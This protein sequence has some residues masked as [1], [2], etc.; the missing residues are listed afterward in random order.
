MR[1]IHLRFSGLQSYREP[2]EIDFQR[3]TEVGLFG[4]FGPTGSGKSTILDAITLSLYGKVERAT[5]N[6]Q[7]IMN[8]NA[9]Q[10]SVSFAFALGERLFRV[11]RSYRR[12][13]S[14]S[15]NIA[16]AR[17]IEEKDG[18]LKVLADKDSTVKKAVEELLGLGVDDF[19][20][21]V[22]LPQGKFAEFL[23]LSGKERRDMLER[24][25]GLSA[26][27][28]QLTER[29]RGRLAEYSGQLAQV[30]AQQEGLGDASQKALQEA[31]K[32]HQAASLTAQTAEQ[33]L[34]EANTAFEEGQKILQLQ[35]ELASVLQKQQEHQASAPAVAAK[36]LELTHSEKAEPLRHLLA[37][38][39]AIAQELAQAQI[40]AQE[41][42]KRVM[43][44]KVQAQEA[45]E[46]ALGAEEQLKTQ[47][48]TL[49]L[50][51]RELAEAVEVEGQLA[52][53]GAEG[54]D[55]AQEL[56]RLEAAIASSQANL[57]A[58]RKKRTVSE[59]ELAEFQKARLE[60]TISAQERERLGKASISLQ[61]LK[62]QEQTLAEV[63]SKYQEVLSLFRQDQKALQE[64][65]TKLLD[66]QKS[67]QELEAQ[68]AAHVQTAPPSQQELM[69]LSEKLAAKKTAVQS[70]SRLDKEQVAL[71]LQLGKVK[72][73]Q[74]QKTILKTELAGKVAAQE[75]A[76]AVLKEA[77][78]REEQAKLAARLAHEL[79]EGQPCPVCG[80]QHHPQPQLDQQFQD[81]SPAIA[82]AEQELVA[83]QAQLI[84][85]E[86]GEETLTR[87]IEEFT[88]KLAQLREEIALEQ[89]KLPPLWQQ[90]TSLVLE[91]K[92]AEE[93]G[94]YSKLKKQTFLWQEAQTSL[95]AALTDAG[96]ELAA[97]E[98]EEAAL[99]AKN[100]AAE[101]S[102]RQT[103]GEL[104]KAQNLLFQAREEFVALAGELSQEQLEARL[105]E[106]S[107]WDRQLEQLQKQEQVLEQELNQLR[108]QVEKA[109]TDLE[110]SK[111]ALAKVQAQKLE[112]DKK[113]DQLQEQLQEITDGASAADLLKVLE[114][115]YAELK[116]RATTLSQKAEEVQA[117]LAEAQGEGER[118][119]EALLGVKNRSQSLE[120]DL[121]QSLAQSG[122]SS[123]V[124]LASALRT[125]EE[126]QKLRDELEAYRQQEQLLSQDYNRLQS[127]IQGRN[128]SP[129]E[130]VQCQRLYLE[131]KSNYEEAFAQRGAAQENY[132]QLQA[133]HQKWQELEA[134][135]VALAQKTDRLETLQAVL[136]GNVFVDF[137]AEEQLAAIAQDASSRLSQLTAGHY[138]LEIGDNCSFEIIDHFNGSIGRP[139][140]T[141]SG[142]ETF[143]A[144]LALALALSTH[145]QLQGTYP[146][147]F[148]FLDEGFGTLDPELLETVITALEMLQQDRM[149]IGVISHVP[150]LRQRLARRLYVEPA[151]PLGRGSRVQL[152]VG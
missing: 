145:I 84:R 46:A 65:Q 77:K 119:A 124:E 6:T 31:E 92:L 102:L 71:E 122:F 126:R 123:Q 45:K 82:T 25:F 136:R 32:Q 37:G 109:A 66:V 54:R 83:L 131:A 111:L 114:K 38:C 112:L 91:E 64:A 138:S 150:E 81:Y 98:K 27:G 86:T 33:K 34:N 11:E 73:E 53:L 50:R 78:K 96:R 134:A 9:D 146:L 110:E 95:Q 149:T 152:E 121:Q 3:L 107:S 104:E 140:N 8:M 35:R 42:E 141:L 148:F 30:S 55:L 2:Q 115:A 106:L 108:T 14:T 100:R 120:Q 72:A 17:L 74:A 60:I 43:Q 15:I 151:E 137:L 67:Y 7:G 142:G 40:R 76:L 47:E 127:Q 5:N 59:G 22:V 58:S 113:Q 18:E 135:R 143:L 128:L 144:S 52:I 20:R 69:A 80:S 93:E 139:V 103:Q 61:K 1:P 132:R 4:I 48:P 16:T 39:K 13:S 125:A 23:N 101:D 90:S 41:A 130:W 56:G 29:V 68:N 36:E 118:S 147:E 12:S 117:L 70:L 57:L 88:S 24:L 85:E 19:T 21:A 49:L 51:K 26:Y 133:K 129:E 105:V 97:W 75:Q 28:R 99:Q 44:F 79:Q 87:R 62:L 63:N 94:T 10:L 89:D 116:E